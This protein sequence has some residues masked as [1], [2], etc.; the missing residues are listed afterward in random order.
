GGVCAAVG[1]G[2]L[3]LGRGQ[4]RMPFARERRR[5][6]EQRRSEARERGGRESHERM[7]VRIPSPSSRTEISPDTWPVARPSRSMKKVS[8]KPVTPQW[9]SDDPAPSARLLYV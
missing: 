3:P 6:D 5:A 4:R 1:E 2:A 8:G 9:P 7:A